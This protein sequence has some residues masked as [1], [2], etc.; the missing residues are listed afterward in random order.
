MRFKR[1][2]IEIRKRIKSISLGLHKDQCWEW[3]GCRSDFGYGLLSFGGKS[4]KAH[5]VSFAIKNG[6]EILKRKD[7]KICHSCDNP[8]CVNP[9]HLFS[10]TQAENIADMINKG[11]KV[12][13]APRLGAENPAAKLSMES[14]RNMRRHRIKTGD[15]YAKIGKIFGVSNMTAFRTV[16]RKSW[17]HV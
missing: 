1:R 3:D 15:S 12:N 5:R 10:G 9:R 4:V 13:P 16:T 11:R 8:P 7:I 6:V 2:L 14:V 17:S